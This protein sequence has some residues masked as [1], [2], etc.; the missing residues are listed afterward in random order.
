MTITG[1]HD[2]IEPLL[3][4]ERFLTAKPETGLQVKYNGIRFT[5]DAW[6]DWQQFIE[7]G[8]PFQ[9]RFA[10]GAAA[11][12]KIIDKNNSELSIPITFYGQHRGGEINNSSEPAQFLHHDN[13]RA[14]F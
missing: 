2:L 8:D 1:N 10:F 11:N 9:E 5:T 7:S 13:A 6:I 12:L 14:F 3:E 4:P